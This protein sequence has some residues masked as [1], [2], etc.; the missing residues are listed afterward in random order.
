MTVPT[1]VLAACRDGIEP[2]REGGDRNGERYEWISEWRSRE[3]QRH[4]EEVDRHK[5]C[6]EDLPN[7]RQGQQRG[8]QQ[9]ARPRRSFQGAIERD[10]REDGEQDEDRVAARLLRPRD[11]ERI[12]SE[13]EPRDCAGERIEQ[14]A[15]E[16]NERCGR[17][18]CRDH[19]RQ[20]HRQLRIA[21]EHRPGLECG[22][23][24]P[25]VALDLSAQR[26]RGPLVAEGLVDPDRLA[27]EKQAPQQRCCHARGERRDFCA[28]NCRHARPRGEDFPCAHVTGASATSRPPSSS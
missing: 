23:V 9:P 16:H 11:H 15:P 20:A 24:Q 22:V 10:R 12:R 3:P 5:Q 25:V 26:L 18:R 19:R 2:R 7:H 8:V 17:E 4:G 21:G 28:E 6:A 1:V 27:R 14:T 13:Q